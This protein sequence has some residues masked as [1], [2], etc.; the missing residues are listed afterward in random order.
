MKISTDAEFKARAQWLWVRFPT[1]DGCPCVA[2]YA[3]WV[4]L[5][6]PILIARPAVC[7]RRHPTSGD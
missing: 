1:K 3:D 6:D 4:M 2:V 5:I 7:R